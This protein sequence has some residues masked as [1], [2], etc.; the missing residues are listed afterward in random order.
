MSWRIPQ[1][2]EPTG[3]HCGPEWS[4]VPYAIS[5]PPRWATVATSLR[6]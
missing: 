5:G 6:N 4:K 3:A 2:L 1:E